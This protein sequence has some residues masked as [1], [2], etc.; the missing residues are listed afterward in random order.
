MATEIRLA[1]APLA[2]S[3]WNGPLRLMERIFCAW[4]EHIA[5]D[6]AQ[7]VRAHNRLSENP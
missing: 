7:K 1:P 6:L 2:R 5:P 3:R 4:L